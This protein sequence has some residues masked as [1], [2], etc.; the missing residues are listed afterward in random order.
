MP[1]VIASY[2]K[3][4]TGEGE[5]CAWCLRFPIVM[6]SRERVRKVLAGEIPDRVPFNFW[7]DRDAMAEYDKTLG[8]NF[9][10]SYYDADVIEVPLL[11]PWWTELH[12][13]VKVESGTVWQVKP[14]LDTLERTDSLA[15]PDPDNLA[16][17]DNIREV[18][19]KYPDKAIFVNVIVPLEHG[20][21]L[22]LY[23][24]LFFDMYDKPEI[25][26]AF[27][28]RI[29][30]VLARISEHLCDMDI[31][32]LY[33]MG[34][35]CDNNGPMMSKDCLRRFW[36]NPIR[37][38]MEVAKKKG[39]WLI[40]HC[41]GRVMDI[42]DLFV[43]AGFDG[44][45]PLQNDVNDTEGFARDYGDRLKVYGGLDNRQ[46][47]PNG[48]PEDVENHVKELF[49]VLGRNGGLILSSH[50]I[51]GYTPKENLDAMVTAIKKCVY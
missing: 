46:I 44:I 32:V 50:D 16:Y 42:L 38:C 31:D 1:T 47:I 7:M 14:L 3:K 40:Y 35:L 15:M 22:R 11:L 23:E 49:Q 25:L 6:T 30:D 34:D 19:E 36:L 29:G 24:G 8:D 41:D 37:K 28:M 10:V 21:N 4:R 12:A 17:Y 33:L 43:E 26:E 39:T 2:F 20:F 51:P 9:R 48:T 27:L 18:R 13:E 45:N 5:G